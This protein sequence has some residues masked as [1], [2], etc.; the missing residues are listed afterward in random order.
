MLVCDQQ[1]TVSVVKILQIFGASLIKSA[2][3]TEFP[4]CLKTII[5]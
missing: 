2:E 4:L 1:T 3:C 5:R